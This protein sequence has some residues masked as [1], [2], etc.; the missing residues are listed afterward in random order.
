M[1]TLGYGVAAL[2]LDASAPPGGQVLHVT[3]G[4]LQLAKA[5][6]VTGALVSVSFDGG[7]TWHP[8]RVTGQAGHYTAVFTAPAGAL[9][10]PRT[11]ATD[12]AGG[13]ITET[14]TS[15]YRVAS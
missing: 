12:A 2:G 1:M 8:A 9:V 4:H 15:A 13:S 5:A 6:A 14:I 3:V 10:T 11:H 7:K